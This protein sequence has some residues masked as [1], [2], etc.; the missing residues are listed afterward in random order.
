M[1]LLFQKLRRNTAQH[2]VEYMTVIILIMAGII[3]GGPYVIRSWNA[4]M[5]GWDDS[6][7]DSLQDTI[8]EAPS[9]P[10]QGCDSEPW[11]NTACKGIWTNQCSGAVI[12]CGELEMLSYQPYNPGG[13]ECEMYPV[14]LTIKCTADP[15][16]CTSWSPALPNPATECGVNATP[17]C[18]DG[19]ARQ[20][21][22]CGANAPE[23][24]CNGD[25]ACMFACNLGAISFAPDRMSYCRDAGQLDDE[26]GLISNKNYD[27]GG[28]C[29]AIKCEVIC[30]GALV[31]D[32]AF[33]QCVCPAGTESWNPVTGLW[34][35]IP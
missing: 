18:P 22:S 35:C 2:S 4:Q 20:T 29:T 26:T 7:T 13:C 14:P 31:P 15:S 17:P 32:I 25:L 12:S 21:R 8:E 27:L 33:T 6:V 28:A 30:R 16:C 5:K 34:E 10:V 24:A 23:S 11:K 1:N 19:Q 3:I 9:F